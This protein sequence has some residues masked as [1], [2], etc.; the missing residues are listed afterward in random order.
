MFGLVSLYFGLAKFGL[1]KFDLQINGLG[2]TDVVC[3]ISAKLDLIW[4][5]YSK[6]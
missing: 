1:A 4:L 5:S 3:K 2:H 6:F